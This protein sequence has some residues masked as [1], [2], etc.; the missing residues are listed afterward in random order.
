MGQRVKDVSVNGEKLNP[1]KIYVVSA[2]EREGDPATMLC[3]IANV[4]EAVNTSYTLHEVMKEYLASN[5]PVTPKPQGNAI[6]LDAPSTLLTQVYGVNY[7][8]V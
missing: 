2:C 5:S 1:E 4:K 7:K 6:I 8:F 3:R